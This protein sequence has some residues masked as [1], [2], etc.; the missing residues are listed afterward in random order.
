MPIDPKELHSRIQDFRKRIV[1]GENVTDEELRTAIRDLHAYRGEAHT[2]LESAS[3]KKAKAKAETKTK[4]QKK[5]AAIAALG[6]LL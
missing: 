3:K 6:D 4:D 5:A 1:A 2:T